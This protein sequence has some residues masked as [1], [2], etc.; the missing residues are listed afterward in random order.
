MFSHSVM[1]RSLSSHELQHSSLPCPSLS[2]AVLLKLMSTEL[3]IPSN[4]LI[5]CARLSSCPQ[6]FPGTK[7]FPMSQPFPSG[8]QR[9]GASASASVLPMNIQGWFPL[10]LTGIISLL[11]KRL[12]KVFS[13][14][15]IWKHQFLGTQPSLW[16]NSHICTWLLEK[17]NISLTIWTFVGKAMSHF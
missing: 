14:T 2:P 15:T 12:S 7:S 6:S 1:S 8:G 16:S 10:G 13:S 5:L 9:I 11:S 17:K 3:M 4:H